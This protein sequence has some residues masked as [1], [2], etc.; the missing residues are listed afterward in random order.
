MV[1]NPQQFGL[2]VCTN[3]FGYI[4]S[5]LTAGLVVTGLAYGRKYRRMMLPV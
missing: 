3:M 5:D 1:M 4:L 2:V